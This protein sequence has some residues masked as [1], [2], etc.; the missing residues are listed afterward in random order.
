M[1][2]ME[3]SVVPLGTKTTGVSLY[4]AGCLQKV[5]A[6]GLE[7]QLTA[8]GTIVVGK[9][10]ELLRLAEDLHQLPFEMGAQR[11]VTTI[12]L[13]DRRDKPLSINGKIKAVQKKCQP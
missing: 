6:S 4:V 1:A 3:I 11:V 2:M 7:H 5:T 10:D 9:V 8:M 13:D 12:K